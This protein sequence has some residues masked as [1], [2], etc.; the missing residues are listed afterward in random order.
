MDGLKRMSETEPVE[1]SI[2]AVAAG[3]E[4]LQ[5]DVR[6]NSFVR[7]LKLVY[8]SGVGMQKTPLYLAIK[9]HD[10]ADGKFFFS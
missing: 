4:C 10:I 9:N 8:H 6:T 7:L 3:R 2:E 5:Q 1:R